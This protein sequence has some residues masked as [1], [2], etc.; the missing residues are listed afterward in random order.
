MKSLYEAR[1]GK[2]GLYSDDANELDDRVQEA[3]GSLIAEFYDRGYNPIEIRL[4]IQDQLHDIIHDWIIK[5]NRVKHTFKF[6]R[7]EEDEHG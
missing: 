1:D 4:V 3:L 5:T 6:G 7:T 2:V